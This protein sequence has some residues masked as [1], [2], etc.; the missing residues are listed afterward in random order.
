MENHPL[1][2]INQMLRENP[3]FS[4]ILDNPLLFVLLGWMILMGAV[5]VFMKMKIKPDPKEIVG[6]NESETLKND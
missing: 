6:S 3:A 5:L 1:E 2:A 4:G